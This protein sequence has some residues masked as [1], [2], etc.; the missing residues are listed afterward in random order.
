MEIIVFLNQ[1]KSR[2]LKSCHTEKLIDCCIFESNI[3]VDVNF[4]IYS[5]FTSFRSMASKVCIFFRAALILS[6]ERDYR[7]LIDA[8]NVVLLFSDVAS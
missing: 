5:T 1:T 3:I 2:D 6:N 4:C 7:T 8:I